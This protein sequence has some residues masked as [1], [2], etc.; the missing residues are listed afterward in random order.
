VTEHSLNTP[1]KK[2]E[3]ASKVPLQRIGGPEDI[4]GVVLFLASPSGAYV[5]GATLTVDGGWLV[6]NRDLKLRAVERRIKL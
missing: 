3:I 4:A 1:E 2:E 6:S 5:N